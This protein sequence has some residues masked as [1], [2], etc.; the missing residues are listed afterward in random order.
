[1][2]IIFLM[3]MAYIVSTFGLA[4]LMASPAIFAFGL[5]PS[6]SWAWAR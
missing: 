1:M 5:V 3:G 4:S 2:A 6:V